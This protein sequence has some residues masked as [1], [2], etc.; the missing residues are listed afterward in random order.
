M[1]GRSYDTL[2]VQVRDILA[3]SDIHGS[4]CD[5]KEGLNVT[6]SGLDSVA[7]EGLA[8]GKSRDVT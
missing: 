4:G 2:K 7:P 8:T 5:G 6:E 1:W 3:E